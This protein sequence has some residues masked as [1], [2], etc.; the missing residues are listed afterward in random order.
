MKLEVVTLPS[1]MSTGPNASTSASAG[2]DADIAVGDAF[3]VVQ[4]TPTQSACSVA[5]GKGVTTGEPGSVQRLILAVD[6][7]DA[8]QATSSAAASRSAGCSTSPG[9]PSPAPTRKAAPTRPTPRSAIQTATDGCSRRSRRGYPAGSGNSPGPARRGR[10]GPVNSPGHTVGPQFRQGTR[11]MRSG[12]DDY[13][14]ANRVVGPRARRPGSRGPPRAVWRP[15]P[16]A[17][18][19]RRRLRCRGG[20][21]CPAVSGR[22]SCPGPAAGEAGVQ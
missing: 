22:E 1:T 3:R 18:H 11:I 14:D 2:L 21:A 9:D 19:R 5:F 13:L 4:L 16:R 6:D 12:Y 10:V 7:I 8:A 17:R 15:V 20:S